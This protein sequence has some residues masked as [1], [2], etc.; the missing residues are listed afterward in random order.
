MLNIQGLKIEERP[1]P[2]FPAAFLV[3]VVPVKGADVGED[4]AGEAVGFEGL[5]I[6]PPPGFPL[7]CP[8]FPKV[9]PGHCMK[10]KINIRKTIKWMNI[11]R[12]V[13]RCWLL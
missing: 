12:R 2:W 5:G 11:S 7:P 6:N 13:Q 9:P 3:G 4:D 8:L 10:M 1:V